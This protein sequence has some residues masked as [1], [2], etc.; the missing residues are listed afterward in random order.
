MICK[1]CGKKFEKIRYASPNDNICGDAC[2]TDNYWLNRVDNKD[3]Y[4]II[5]GNCY[6][7]ETERS[8][9]LMG[10]D[11]RRFRIRMLADSR[12][13]VTTNLWYNGEVPQKYRDMLPDNAEFVGRD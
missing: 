5:H 10:F 7:V 1:I 11:G 3:E 13:I 4:L 2:Y 6:Y 8:G 12:E 9:G